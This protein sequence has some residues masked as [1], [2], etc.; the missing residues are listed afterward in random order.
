[1]MHDWNIPWRFMHFGFGGLFMWIIFIAILALVIY[2]VV[3]MSKSTPTFK[4]HEDA[5]L[6]ILKK[7]YARGEISKDDFDNMKKDLM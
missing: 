2:V 6:D 7:R 1:M 5:P 4:N 3:R